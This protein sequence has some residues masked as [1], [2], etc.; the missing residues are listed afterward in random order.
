MAPMGHRWGGALA[1][2]ALGHDTE[3]TLIGA[4]VGTAVGYGVG[5]EIDKN[6]RRNY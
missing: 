4:G 5:N 2:Q 3:A 1:S 6:R